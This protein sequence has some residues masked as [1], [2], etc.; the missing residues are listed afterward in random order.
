M[1]SKSRDSEFGRRTCPPA[2]ASLLDVATRCPRRA[3]LQTPHKALYKAARRDCGTDQR[4]HALG[5]VQLMTPRPRMLSPSKHGHACGGLEVCPA[6]PWPTSVTSQNSKR[7]RLRSRSW[8]ARE[9]ANTLPDIVHVARRWAH[10]SS[11]CAPNLPSR[12]SRIGRHLAAQPRR[13]CSTCHLP[14]CIL[15]FT[16]L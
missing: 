3:R 1:G 15:P 10:A 4:V 11:P 7:T 8:P 14:F 13:N 9:P 12:H 2:D 16:L 5:A 6:G